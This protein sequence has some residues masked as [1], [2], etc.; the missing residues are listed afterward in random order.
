MR[1]LTT[2][3]R[4]LSA[5]WQSLVELRVGLAI[6]E[7][8]HFVPAAAALDGLLCH[9]FFV[10]GRESCQKST[11]LRSSFSGTSLCGT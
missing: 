2:R 5:R 10:G 4:E 9:C 3:I 1:D 11:R 7:P 6:N 8:I